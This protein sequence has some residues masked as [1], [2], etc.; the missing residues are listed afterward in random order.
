MAE[1]QKPRAQRLSPLRL[2]PIFFRPNP[3]SILD[4]PCFPKSPIV[5]V[6]LTFFHSWLSAA[7]VSGFTSEGEGGGET[8][9]WTYLGVQVRPVR[10]GGGCATER[11]CTKVLTA[12]CSTLCDPVSHGGCREGTFSRE[13][14]QVETGRMTMR[15]ESSKGRD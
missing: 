11:L 12:R 14:T 9:T 7:T 6:D 10:V 3:R 15:A 1:A 4:E 8:H 5:H 13:G 2:Q